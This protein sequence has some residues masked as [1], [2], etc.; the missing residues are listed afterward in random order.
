MAEHVNGMTHFFAIALN[1][2]L[3]LFDILR[4]DLSLDKPIQAITNRQH[5]DN[6]SNT[7]IHNTTIVTQLSYELYKESKCSVYF[8]ILD[9]GSSPV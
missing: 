4:C 7:E 2:R 1:H 8:S 3:Q 5:P 6:Q 9:T